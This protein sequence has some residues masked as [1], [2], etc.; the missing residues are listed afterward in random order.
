MSFIAFEN[1]SIQAQ[2]EEIRRAREAAEAQA[3]AEKEQEV[4]RQVVESNMPAIRE[5]VQAE[6][7]K[8]DAQRAEEKVSQEAE[9]IGLQLQAMYKNAHLYKNEIPTL[10]DQLQEKMLRLKQIAASKPHEPSQTYINQVSA[11]SNVRR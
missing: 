10:E 7:S 1:N 8:S 11:S 3:R 5:Q 2:A 4:T 9:D 6:L